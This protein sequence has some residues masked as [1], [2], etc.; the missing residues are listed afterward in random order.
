MEQGW[1]EAAGQGRAAPGGHL[2]W[3]ASGPA[4][5]VPFSHVPAPGFL[6]G[7]EQRRAGALST[8]SQHFLLPPR[9]GL[10]FVSVHDC[11]WTHALTVDVM[12]Q[13]KVSRGPRE[14]GSC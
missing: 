1:E 12:N 10:T 13:V 9:Q 11:Y 4:W 8:A 2:S 14:Q 6:W 7:R 3:R 5:G